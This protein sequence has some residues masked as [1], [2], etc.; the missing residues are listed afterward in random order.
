M[1]VTRLKQYLLF[2][3]V[4]ACVGP[5]NVDNKPA[6]ENQVLCLIPVEEV[7]ITQKVMKPLSCA[8]DVIQRQEHMFIGYLLPTLAVLEKRIKYEAMRELAYCGPLANSVLTGIEKRFGHLKGKKELVISSCL[9]PRFKLSWIED[10]SMRDQA[11]NYIKTE[12]ASTLQPEAQDELSRYLLVPVDHP[13]SQMKSFE[14]LHRLFLKYNT[15][16][17]ISSAPPVRGAALTGHPNDNVQYA[18]PEPAAPR[19]TDVWQTA[20]RRPLCYHC[21]RASTSTVDTPTDDLSC[22][23]SNPTNH[24]SDMANALATLRSTSDAHHP[25]RRLSAVNTAHHR[26][27]VHRRQGH[28][29]MEKACL[30]CVTVTGKSSYNDILVLKRAALTHRGT[31]MFPRIPTESF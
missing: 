29:T 14:G 22:V 6:A 26:Y 18:L 3:Q 17:A 13:L 27:N 2:I 25:Q 4:L 11:S 8:L 5:R 9:I 20:D 24:A 1:H 15:A 12:L 21:G 28:N 23:G 16:A 31:A 19:K 30:L 7:F 10:G